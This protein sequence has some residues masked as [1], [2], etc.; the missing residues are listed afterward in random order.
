M[1]FDWFSWAAEDEQVG[2]GEE[3]AAE[4]WLRLLLSVFG[5]EIE[6]LREFEHHHY[7]EGKVARKRKTV[8]EGKMEQEWGEN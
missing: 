2:A 7:S 5:R 1:G 4:E 6:I 8:K 3:Q